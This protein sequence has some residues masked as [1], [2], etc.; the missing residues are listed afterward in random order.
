MKKIRLLLLGL[1]ALCL[2]QACDSS[3]N[4]DDS[5]ISSSS[6]QNENS[7]SS[8]GAGSS[9]SVIS[10]SST[11]PVEVKYMTDTA[12]VDY[13]GLNQVV[14][15][16]F[17][18]G[19]KTVIAHDTWHLAFDRDLN[20]V[21]NGGNYGFGVAACSTG[22]ADFATDFSSWKD[23]TSRY[24]R[25]DTNANVWGKSYVQAGVLTHQ[26]YLAKLESGAIYKFQVTGVLSGNSG[27]KLKI[28]ALN[29]SSAEEVEFKYA[30]GYGYTFINIVN[31]K[32]VLVE[33]P[34]NEWDIRFGRT[35]YQMGS[36]TSG[37]STI[38]VNSQGGVAAAS[39]VSENDIELSSVVE[40]PAASSFSATPLAIG[41]SW[42]V[43][44]PSTKL[45]TMQPVVYVVKTTEGYY[46]KMRL[47]NFMGPNNEYYYSLFKYLYQADGA[48]RFAK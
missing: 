48:T 4:S 7:S 37:R 45:F 3:T 23:S 46:A 42:V 17:S 20:L 29:A 30:E 32:G 10:S 25:T 43:Y 8:Q 41:S 18:T 21:A 26:V 1:S 40:M 6:V 44:S 39:I 22:I 5:G 33:P 2:L 9:S 36:G 24:T 19:K 12:A 47:L 35:E 34:K 15:Y 28:G 13:K 14:Y 38:G 27:L 11:V 31:L 16:D